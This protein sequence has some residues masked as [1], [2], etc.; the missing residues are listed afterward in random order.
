MS[1]LGPGPIDSWRGRGPAN[2]SGDFEARARV[3]LAV[4]RLSQDGLQEQTRANRCL[5]REPT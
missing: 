2:G 5:R 4:S 1:K 3:G